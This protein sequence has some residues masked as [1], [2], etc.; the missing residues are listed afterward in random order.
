MA[1]EVIV[2]DRTPT[3]IIEIVNELRE[4][5][6]EQY[7]DFNF[8]YHPSTQ[9]TFGHEA[10]TRRYTVFTF[11]TEKYATFFALKYSSGH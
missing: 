3:A 10:P 2:Y 6:Y 11:Y 1:V 5:G 9:D 7:K 8:E 4:Q